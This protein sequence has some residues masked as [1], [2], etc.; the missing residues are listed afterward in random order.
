M[1][2]HP[3][4]R[5]RSGVAAAADDPSASLADLQVA[6]R[7]QMLNCLVTP[8]IGA[9]AEIGVADQLAGGGLAVADLA[10]RT[11]ANAGALRRV[12]RLLA[13]RGIFQSLGSDRYQNSA[14]SD[15]LRE[16][17]AGSFR[18]LAIFYYRVIYPCGSNMSHS[19]LTGQ[20]SFPEVF[21]APQFEL[22]SEWPDLAGLLNRAMADSV[23]DRG[24]V[25]EAFPW[26][27][28][29][30]VVDLGGG[31]GTLCG[32]LLAR[33]THLRGLIVDL[34]HTV[35]DVPGVIERL[36]VADRCEAHGGSF[37]DPLPAGHDIYVLSAVLHDW[38][39]AD[40]LRILR[41]CREA[42]RDDSRLLILEQ[43]MPD[44]DRPH[45]SVAADV[46]MLLSVTGRER[47]LTEWNHLL[48]QAEYSIETI[49]TGPSTAMIVAK[50]R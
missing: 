13:S 46:M 29:R 27:T 26:Q 37:F 15:L 20:P 39:D 33:H 1:L 32:Q 7:L 12:L 36:G 22:M 21:G 42:T 35:A 47:T 49:E 23:R 3:D 2:G 19:L 11:G 25:L 28:V 44:D 14:V 6:L 24:T 31:T 50:P 9:V 18:H 43:V 41:R 40:S 16:D 10:S 4:D 17:H 34:P 38:D 8:A 30:S 5:G 48:G 45:V